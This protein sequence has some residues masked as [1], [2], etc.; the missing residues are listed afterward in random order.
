M[1]EKT[2]PSGVTNTQSTRSPAPPSTRSVSP[3]RSLCHS[4]CCW[5]P[6]QSWCY[7]FWLALFLFC[8]LCVVGVGV[9]AARARRQ[10]FRSFFVLHQINIVVSVSTS[11]IV[12]P[13]TFSRPQLPLHSHNEPSF[14]HRKA[15]PGR[16][17]G[18]PS[19]CRRQGAPRATNPGGKELGCRTTGPAACQVPGRL[20]LAGSPGAWPVRLTNSFGADH[21]FALVRLR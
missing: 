1:R 16:R 9:R 21:S 15:R 8:V 5:L 7:S 13:P 10:V 3:S 17:T 14:R 6:Q 11:F 12:V 18:Q 2:S 20:R 19:D 4:L